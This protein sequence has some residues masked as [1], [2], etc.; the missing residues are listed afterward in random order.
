M[1]LFANLLTITFALQMQDS[2]MVDSLNSIMKSESISFFDLMVEGGV[3]MI[4]I[5]ILFFLAVY[6]IAERLSA[7]GRTKTDTPVFLAAIE[8]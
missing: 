2:S 5:F 1:T 3:L 7:L 6:V 4:P 8:S